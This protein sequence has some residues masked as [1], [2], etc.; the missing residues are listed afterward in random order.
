[1]LVMNGSEWLRGLL[2]TFQVHYS[3]MVYETFQHFRKTNL[4]KPRINLKTE[5]NLQK[6][7]I[8]KP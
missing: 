2:Q 3:S 1:M 7:R 5:T 6:P 4:Q 8:Y